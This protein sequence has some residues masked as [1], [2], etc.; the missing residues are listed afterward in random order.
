[1]ALE[2]VFVTKFTAS[3]TFVP[4]N[5]LITS[6]TT[7]YEIE[8]FD[9]CKQRQTMV[10]LRGAKNEDFYSL[11]MFL[12]MYKISNQ[13]GCKDHQQF[14]SFKPK[15]TE[16]IEHEQNTSPVIANEHGCYSCCQSLNHNKT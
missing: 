6:L 3:C 8:S 14:S 9:K 13:R 16:N 12:L 4:K 15:C 11:Y 2:L 5:A 1:M 7:K 10:R